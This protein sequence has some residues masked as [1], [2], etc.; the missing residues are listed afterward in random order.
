MKK[1]LFLTNHLQFS[2]GVAR[3]LLNLTNNLDPNKYDISI[4]ALYKKDLEFIKQFNKNIKIFSIFNFYFRGLRRIVK[5]IP[6]HFILNKIIRD[7][8]DVI[9]AYQ[10]GSPTE[11]LSSKNLKIPKIAFMHGYDTTDIKYHRNYDKIIC[12]AESSSLNYKQVVDFPEKVTYCH[13]ILEVDDIIQKSN[14][15]FAFQE[16]FNLLQTPKLIFVGRLSPEKG[17]SRTLRA[18][19][20][21]KKENIKFSYTIIGDGPIRKQIENEI[22]NLGLHNEVKMFGFQKNPYKFL[23]ACD[24]YICSSYGEGL[25][26]ACIEASILGLDIISTNVSGAKEIIL[27]PDVGLVCENTDES[28]YHCLKDYIANKFTNNEWKNNKEIAKEK[29]KK[30]NIIKKFD[31]IIDDIIK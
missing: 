8:F 3:A 31:S 12:V 11:L 9:I 28:I 1:I 10:H 5:L 18:L 17:I 26:T 29:W 20:K 25:C 14:E 22:I 16:D 15:P 7:R 27:N 24:A 23:K 4:C 13:N 21:I 6:S 30:E 19:E 2:D